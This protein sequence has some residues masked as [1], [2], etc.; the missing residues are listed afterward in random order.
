METAA[1]KNPPPTASH[2]MPMSNLTVLTRAALSE[3]D[4]ASHVLRL[5][6]AGATL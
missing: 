2:R 4:A 5:E 1:I 6:R 3:A